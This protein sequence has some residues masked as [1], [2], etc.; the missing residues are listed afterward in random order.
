MRKVAWPN[1]VSLMPFRFMNLR[2]D[3]LAV[4][5]YRNSTGLNAKC[6]LLNASLI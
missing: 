1:Q 2:T 3:A 6:Q 5:Q 4:S